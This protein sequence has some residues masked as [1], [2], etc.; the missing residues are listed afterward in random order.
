MRGFRW[1]AVGA[2]V[3]VVGVLAFMIWSGG[4]ATTPATSA[5]ETASTDLPSTTAPLVTTSPA[6]GE[7]EIA[8][9]ADGTDQ[10]ESLMAQLDAIPDGALIRID[11]GTYRIDGTVLLENRHG[12]TLDLS[13]VTFHNEI[14]AD[15]TD[16][17]VEI[18]DSTDITLIGLRM[19]STNT[20]EDPDRPGF[21]I[22]NPER[23]HQHAFGVYDS[24]GISLRGV[25][26]SAVWGDGLYIAGSSDG[27][28]VNGFTVTGVG[29]QGIA[30]VEGANIVVDG[31]TLTGGRQSGFD[32]EPNTSDAVVRNV[33]IRNATISSWQVAFTAGG[34]GFVT[35]VLVDGYTVHRSVDAPFRVARGDG[36]ANFEFRNLV[37]TYTISPSAGCCGISLEGVDGVIIDTVKMDFAPQFDI[38]A[39]RCVDC[40]DVSVSNLDFTGNAVDLVEE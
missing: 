38:T 39:I 30:I 23:E 40:T 5:P 17:H 4:E 26:A 18:V 31:Y 11:P 10:T 19:E 34:A 7:F 33:T 25:A 2:V 14:A 1:V 35:D 29:R 8:L 6:G 15:R 37:V 28:N 24:Q 16:R 12:L 13:N 36:R 9:N 32:I 22:Y 20:Q 3:V 21:P 27:V